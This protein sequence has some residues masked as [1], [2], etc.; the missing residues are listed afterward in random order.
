MFLGEVDYVRWFVNTLTQI[1]DVKVLAFV[2][3]E[4]FAHSAHKSAIVG[5]EAGVA[6]FRI[7]VEQT[8]FELYY[9]VLACLVPDRS[10]G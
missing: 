1:V 7:E 8:P 5:I 10:R 3:H 9:W 4:E 2:N 6:T